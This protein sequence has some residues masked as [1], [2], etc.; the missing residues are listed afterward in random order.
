MENSAWTSSAAPA[1]GATLAIH[2]SIHALKD[3][4]AELVRAGW[5]AE[6][7]A[8]HIAARE[9]LGDVILFDISEGTPQGKSLDIAEASAV[10]GK[11]VALK[12]ANDYADIAGADVCIVKIGRAHV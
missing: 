5:S 3:V 9:E 7:L 2:L 10:F 1:T 4:V 6:T 12:G 8:S 11:D